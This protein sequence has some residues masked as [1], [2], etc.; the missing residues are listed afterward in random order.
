MITALALLYLTLGLKGH[1]YGGVILLLGWCRDSAAAIHQ[2]DPLCAW[3]GRCECDGNAPRRGQHLSCLHVAAAPQ[4]L[5][6]MV[7]PRSAVS[8]RQ[9]RATAAGAGLL[10][11]PHPELHYFTICSFYLLTFDTHIST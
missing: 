10:E 4:S 2:P 11:L 8:A 3:L 1:V 5:R 9:T 6:A 7:R